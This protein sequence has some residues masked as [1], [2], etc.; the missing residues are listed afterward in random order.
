MHRGELLAELCGRKRLIAVAGTHGKTTTSGMLVHALRETGAD[1]AF[2]LGGE[3]PGAGPGGAPPTPAG[4][5]ASGSSPR[6]TRATA[7]SCSCDPRSRSSPTSSSTTTRTGAREAELI[8]AFAALRVTGRRG[9][10]PGGQPT[11]SAR[12]AGAVLGFAVAPPRSRR[13]SPPH[14]GERLEA[15]AGGSRFRLGSGSSREVRLVPGAT[16]SPTPRRARRS[17]LALDRSGPRRAAT[18]GARLPGDAPAASSSRAAATARSIYDDYA[19]HPTEVRGVARP[20]SGSSGRAADRRL[21][22]PPLLAHQGTGL[23]VRR[24]R[25]PPPTRS[26]C[27][28]STRRAR[29]RSARSPGSAGSTSPRPPPTAPADGRCGG[30][31]DAERRAA[32]LADRLRDG[33]RARHARRRRRLPPRRAP[34]RRTS[35]AAMSAPPEACRAGLSRSPA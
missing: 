17:A 32:G 24:A 22:A 5:K 35:R 9:R 3:L 14:A 28:T 6:P 11:G 4:A 1:P 20:L 27:S 13:A 19:H 33:R 15:V 26:P 31:R 7:A 34:G 10:P 25:S 18:A 21:P 2:L 12:R 30:S 29:S 23:A 16:T 8:E